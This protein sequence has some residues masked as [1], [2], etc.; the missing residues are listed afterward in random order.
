[1]RTGKLTYF[2][3]GIFVGAAAGVLAGLMFAPRSGS[4]TRRRLAFE[5]GRLQEAAKTVAERAETAVESVGSRMDHYLGRDEEV[6]WRKVQEL[7]DG[8]QRYSRTVIS[9]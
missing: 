6:A 7:R 2:I 5:A 4:E 8:V 1:M 3:I 9:S